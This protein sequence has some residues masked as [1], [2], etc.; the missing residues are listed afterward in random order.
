M[1]MAK[2]YK[3]GACIS[4]MRALTGS[5]TTGHRI[6]N[7]RW[8]LYVIIRY[9]L[10]IAQLLGII[11]VL[12]GLI[13]MIIA[14]GEEDGA[15]YQKAVMFIGVGIVLIVL[16]TF[17]GFMAGGPSPRYFLLPKLP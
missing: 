9:L 3:V 7:A 12:V 5:G 6:P 1:L 11:M 2:N 17:I 13:K 14:F 15:G 10:S 16:R 8:S 4:A